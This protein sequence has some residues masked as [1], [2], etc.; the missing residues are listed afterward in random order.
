M[1]GEL[2]LICLRKDGPGVAYP[3]WLRFS[4]PMCLYFLNLQWYTA[5][6]KDG[7]FQSGFC[8]NKGLNGLLIPS[9]FLAV[10]IPSKLGQLFQFKK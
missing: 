8:S 4:L 5:G 3:Q 2:V 7:V 10:S 1:F 9:L 6:M